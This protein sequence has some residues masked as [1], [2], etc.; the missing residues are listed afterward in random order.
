[1]Q[2]QSVA[3]STSFPCRSVFA[4]RMIL[5]P[6]PLTFFFLHSPFSPQLHSRLLGIRDTHNYIMT[7]ISS[8][9]LYPACKTDSYT[10]PSSFL[11]S[12]SRLTTVS[13]FFSFVPHYHL[14]HL[15]SPFTT[16]L[17]HSVSFLFVFVSFFFFY[18]NL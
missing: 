17:F 12:P 9:L 3:T 6:P 1:M 4:S 14:L 13:L 16:Y 7:P 18:F 15:S 10:S 8:S 11:S 5:N 2:A